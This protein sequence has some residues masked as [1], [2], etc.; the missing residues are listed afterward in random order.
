MCHCFTDYIFDSFSRSIE[1]PEDEVAR[2]NNRAL[3]NK[4]DKSIGETCIIRTW[5][6]MEAPCTIACRVEPCRRR[7]RAAVLEWRLKARALFKLNSRV[8][9]DLTL[10]DAPCHSCVPKYASGT[11]L[12]AMLD[13]LVLHNSPPELQ[14]STPHVSSHME[15]QCLVSPGSQPSVTHNSTFDPILWFPRYRRWPRTCIWLTTSWY[16]RGSIVASV[17]L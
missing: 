10:E 9:S 5:S 14:R 6:N 7:T 11:P 8:I 17:K 12:I 16:I 4:S 13:R 2:I 15:I 1:S 3:P